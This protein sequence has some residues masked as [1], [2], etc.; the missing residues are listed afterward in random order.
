MGIK[1]EKPK[2]STKGTNSS[3]KKALDGRTKAA[4]IMSG[5]YDAK[6]K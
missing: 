3:S 4:K 6:K 1:V 5:K 2:A